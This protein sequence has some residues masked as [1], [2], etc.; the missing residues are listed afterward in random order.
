MTGSNTIG[1][2]IWGILG[3]KYGFVNCVIASSAFLAIVGFTMIK[4]TEVKGLI[5][6]V[7]FY[8]FFSGGFFSLLGPTTAA[9]VESLSDLGFAIGWGSFLESFTVLTAEPIAGA[10]LDAP[11]YR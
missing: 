2:V 5:P 9:Y 6:F 4:A 11:R 10:L 7:I 8:G 3:D 1:R